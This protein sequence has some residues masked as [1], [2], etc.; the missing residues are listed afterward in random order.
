M[1]HSIKMRLIIVLFL[2]MSSTLIFCWLINR[3]FL[4]R[5]YENHVIRRLG[6]TYNKIE[7][8]YNSDYIFDQSLE[9]EQ[10]ASKQNVSLYIFNSFEY[11]DGVFLDVKFPTNLNEFQSRVLKNEVMSYYYPKL[12]SYKNKDPVQKLL[13]TDKYSVTRRFDSRLRVNF[14]ELYG[15]LTNSDSIFIRTN[16]DSITESVGV[17]NSFFAY[18]GIASILIG[19]WIMYIIGEE[20]TK[21]I[22]VL[23]GITKEISDLNFNIKY[24]GS[25]QDELGELGKSV[26]I[27]SDKL[28]NTISSLKTANNELKNDIEKREKLE[29]M[30]NEFLSNVTHELKTP[31]ALI[32]GYA[33]GLKDNISEDSESKDF[34]CNVIIEESAKMNNMVQKLLSLNELEFGGGRLKFDRF[35]II[36]LINSV[37]ASMQMFYR[38]KNVTLKFD[39][40]ITCFVWGDKYMIEEVVTNY[41]SNALNYVSADVKTGEKIISVDIKENEDR[42]RISVFNTGEPIPKED[43]DKIWDKFYKVDKAR[44]RE[45][46]GS[47][48]GL[49]IVKAI[50]NQLNKTYGVKNWDNGVEF[51]FELE[52]KA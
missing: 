22:R 34:Y 14:I 51:W 33:E 29:E 38:Q 35:D 31:I 19:S 1:K 26:N 52:T 4:E 27:L 6:N 2:L 41:M 32:Q 10:I 37:V 42:V 17:A 11:T 40:S 30:R 43:L 12:A 8:K 25:R 28:E 16:Y 5:Y 36:K 46:G 9:F 45:Y 44:T 7:A 39:N 13:E 50:M 18:V 47:G 21:P 24:T 49:S 15:K 48:I 23:S 3:F 20:F